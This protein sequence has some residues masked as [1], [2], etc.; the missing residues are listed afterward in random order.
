MGRNASIMHTS[1]QGQQWINWFFEKGIE[2]T[3]LEE[4][5]W[6]GPDIVFEVDW[7]RSTDNEYTVVLK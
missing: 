5:S 2:A 7:Q 1:L 4:Y 3:K 6:S